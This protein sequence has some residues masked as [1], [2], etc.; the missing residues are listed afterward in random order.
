MDNVP[1]VVD[2]V[3]SMMNEKESQEVPRTQIPSIHTEPITAILDS[4]TIALTTANNINDHSSSTIVDDISAPTLELYDGLVKSYNLDKDLFASYGKAYSLKR[5]REDKDKDKDPPAGPNQG[6]RKRKTSKD[7]EPPRSS[8]SKD[9]Q[10]SSS[11]GTKSTQFVRAA[12]SMNGFKKPECPSTPNPDGMLEINLD[13]NLLNLISQIAKAEKPP[14]TL[15]ELMCTPIDFSAFVM[16]HLKID[17]LTQQHLVGPTYNLLKG[18]CK[19][20]REDNSLHK[21]KEGDFPNL[22][23]RDIEDML[24]LLVHKKILNLERDDLFDLNVALRMFTRSVVIQK[25][26]EDLQ[27]GVIKLPKKLNI[28][29]PDTYNPTV[30]N[31]PPPQKTLNS[32]RNILHDIASNLR[33]EYLPKR[34]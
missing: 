27:L 15:D 4:S 16:N 21:F 29:K 19:I 1:P 13:F 31:M 34:K 7:A 33:I 28:T 26:V 22:N 3:A 30:S 6:S 23:L 32:I 5:Y 20:R 10:S 18:T 8:K 17:N 2:E 25:R 12:L 24:L 14:L 9:S 11:K